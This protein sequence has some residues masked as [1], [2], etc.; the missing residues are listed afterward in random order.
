MDDPAQGC[1]IVDGSNQGFQELIPLVKETNP[2]VSAHVQAFAGRFV[3]N[4]LANQARGRLRADG[5]ATLSE[6]VPPPGPSWPPVIFL[7]W[8]WLL[9]SLVI[10]EA[11]FLVRCRYL[12]GLRRYLSGRPG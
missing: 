1:G 6:Y 11:V 10:L 9:H 2:P 12:A 7:A 5:D 4:I 8:A 3:E